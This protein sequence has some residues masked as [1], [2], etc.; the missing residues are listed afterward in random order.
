M[1]RRFESLESHGK[2]HHASGH[3]SLLLRDRD[4]F[5]LVIEGHGELV[6]TDVIDDQ[7]SVID[8]Q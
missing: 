2:I 4:K 1:S 8:H 3:Q 5:W 6:A 7:S